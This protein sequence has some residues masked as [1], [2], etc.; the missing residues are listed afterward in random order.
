MRV[1]VHVSRFVGRMEGGLWSWFKVRKSGSLDGLSKY[2]S[3]IFWNSGYGLHLAVPRGSSSPEGWAVEECEAPSALPAAVLPYGELVKAQ[4][5]LGAAIVSPVPLPEVMK[6]YSRFRASYERARLAAQWGKGKALEELEWARVW[7]EEA[8]ECDFKVYAGLALR[9]LEPAEL[10]RVGL[11]RVQLRKLEES[12]ERGDEAALRALEGLSKPAGKLLRAKAKVMKGPLWLTHRQLERV[13]YA[14]SVVYREAQGAEVFL[15][16]DFSIAVRAGSNSNLLVVGESQ[17]GKSTLVGCLLAQLA[18]RPWPE[19]IVVFDW[20]GEYAFLERYGFRVIEALDPVCNPLALG[21]MAA[22]EILQQ[23]AYELTESE[24][25]RFGI[26]GLT[27]AERALMEAERE[28]A[29]ELEDA[30]KEQSERGG[31]LVDVVRALEG[32]LG[33][34]RT[35]NERDAVLAALHRVKLVLHPALCAGRWALPEGRVVVDLS[36]LPSARVKKAVALTML[37]MVYASAG[38]WRGLAVVDEVHSYLIPAGTRYDSPTI[39]MIANQLSKFGV[40]IWGVGQHY[41]LVPSGLRGARA[42]AVFRQTDPDALAQVE[43]SMGREAAETVRNLPPRQFYLFADCSVPAVR[44]PPPLAVRVAPEMVAS[45]A[46][47]ENRQLDFSQ[48]AARFGIEY[49]DLVELYVR[50]LPH[51]SAII[52]FAAKQA[53]PEEVEEVKKLDLEPEQL[54]ALSTLYATRY[55]LPQQP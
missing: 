13:H 38:R 29:R 45:K 31:T 14:L 50:Y 54:R 7:W 10:V 30:V 20:T 47:R 33:S 2:P 4:K 52:R 53:S 26:G 51:A 17:T 6:R 32:R 11:R 1:G 55:G 35:Q 24:R 9:F 44:V 34:V 43:K 15:A 8:K 27:E 5:L 41:H 16:P 46:S 21:P 23:A 19:N 28:S 12:A 39:T 36:R 42:M 37:R 25:G 18:S 49:A 48:F 40:A 3:F 22:L